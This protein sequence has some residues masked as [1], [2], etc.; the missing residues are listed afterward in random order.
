MATN[1]TPL[2]PVYSHSRTYPKLFQAPASYGCH[3][4][5]S[6]NSLG[7]KAAKKLDFLIN[8]P[9]FECRSPT[10][11]TPLQRGWGNSDPLIL[12]FLTQ[13]L[14]KNEMELGL[15][16]DAL[17]IFLSPSPSHREAWP[18]TPAIRTP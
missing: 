17:P 6:I 8:L 12:L 4:P 13:S 10:S 9:T 14:D 7:Q 1:L 11:L 5:S 16:W 3:R 18:L 2:E 15:C